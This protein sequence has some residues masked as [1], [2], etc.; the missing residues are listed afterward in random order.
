MST[1]YCT[2]LYITCWQSF[3]KT[4]KTVDP[5]RHRVNPRLKPWAI[6]NGCCD[7]IAHLLMV[8]EA[9][10]ILFEP[11]QR[12]ADNRAS[13]STPT[14]MYSSMVSLLYSYLTFPTSIKTHILLICSNCT[15]YVQI[16]GRGYFDIVVTSINQ[17]DCLP[18]V[19]SHTG[20]VSEKR[21]FLL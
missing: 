10:G 14:G 13:I 9:K 17:V 7:T 18:V 1:V 11:F 6:K 20:V 3:L 4:V 15:G 16:F 8:G 12:F 21:F 19:F 5:P 2:L